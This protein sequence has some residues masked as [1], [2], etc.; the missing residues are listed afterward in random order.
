MERLTAG[1]LQ[2]VV[3]EPEP[4]PK[5]ASPVSGGLLARNVGLNLL[6]QLVP[7]VVAFIAMPIVIHRLGDARFGVLSLTLIVLGYFS[8]LDFGLGRATTKFVAE[9]LG[10]GERP[11]QIASIFWTSLSIQLVLGMV[12]GTLLASSTPLLVRYVL[13][14][15]TALVAET[16]FVLYICSI[17]VLLTLLTAT[18]SGLLEA[19]QRFDIVN[20]L[21][22]PSNV[23]SSVIPVVVLSFKG[24]LVVIV[25]CLALKNLI[26]AFLFFW[27]ARR[28]L[29]RMGAMV[30]IEFARIPQ[31]F[32]FGGWIT[33]TY[34]LSSL[35]A[36]LD[37]F[38][39]AS[40]LSTT[41]VAYYTP[42]YEV[43]SRLWIIPQ[44]L[45]MTLFPAF[46]LLWVDRRGE[47][48]SVFARAYKYLI[49]TTAPV[50][51][52]IVLL[53]GDFLR[54][55]LGASF[56]AK[57]TEVMQILAIGFFL[58]CQAWVP[59]TLLISA[60]RPDLVAKLFALELPIYVGTAYWLIGKMGIEGAAIAWA[61]RG[62]LE[63]IIF[64][65]TCCK[66]ASFRSEMFRQ[67]GVLRAIFALVSLM[68]GLLI[69]RWVGNGHLLTSAVGGV[70]LTCLFVLMAYTYA[71]DAAERR[72]MKNPFLRLLRKSEV[73]S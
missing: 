12:G 35:L 30:R 50:V 63:A 3:P 53:A 72:A 32:K 34:V 16:E 41:A 17:S 67:Y 62:G 28:L 22:V 45:F 61:F 8:L 4:A 14:V 58:N 69:L 48:E 9:C 68:G 25:A 38:L 40:R 39:I 47:L 19:Y 36:Y 64:F 31:L 37:R 21:R 5:S 66:I 57:S 10:R 23:L 33:V 29:G 1:D 56:A 15:P 65:A 71:L 24:G 27:Q 2:T 26:L 59:S 11:D 51:A 60:G 54:L 73:P 6:G 52:C 18:M 44:S 49:L 13:K 42:P 7:A 43:V 46:S 20:A 70:L 55:W